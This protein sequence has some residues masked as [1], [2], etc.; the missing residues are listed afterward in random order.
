MH[1]F[2]SISIGSLLSIIA[3]NENK[4]IGKTV[5]SAQKKT[6]KI[7]KIELNFFDFHEIREKRIS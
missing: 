1:C 2:L 5:F 7:I 3:Q 6:N 4:A